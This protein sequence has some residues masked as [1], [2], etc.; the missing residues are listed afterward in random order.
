MTISVMNY[1]N[2]FCE[3]Y[4]SSIINNDEFFSNIVVRKTNSL[5]LSIEK[6]INEL[7]LRKDHITVKEIDFMVHILTKLSFISRINLIKAMNDI[8]RKDF[9][10]SK[11]IRNSKYIIDYTLKN[12]VKILIESKNDIDLY[13][14]AFLLNNDIISHTNRVFFTMIKFIKYYNNCIDNNIVSDIRQNFKN[15]YL[16]YYK[17]VLKKFNIN[18]NI[19][20]LE[21]VYKYGLRELFRKE[22]VEI[23]IAS[24]WHDIANITPDYSPN[25]DDEYYASKGYS[26]LKYF[27]NYGDNISLIVGMHNEYF[28]YGNG[29]FLDYYNSIN[30]SEPNYIISFDYE[31]VLRLGSISYFPS[32]I[33]EIADLFDHLVYKYNEPNSSKVLEYIR[34]DYLNKEVKVDPIIFDI[35]S[36]FVYSQNK[37]IA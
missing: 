32:K 35:F 2:K 25:S 34:E 15:K 22:I 33:L 6:D 5:L 20:K 26:Y 24:F 31:D 8:K 9:K 36:S 16:K 7:K 19:N 37:L 13:N 11:E 30:N 18:N 23:A 21:D 29:I 1:T 4:G 14:R 28:G 3:I 10:F 17:S 12:I 27:I